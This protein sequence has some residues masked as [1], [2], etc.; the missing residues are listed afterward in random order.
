MRFAELRRRFRAKRCVIRMTGGLDRAAWGWRQR[1]RRPAAASDRK[2]NRSRPA[3]CA[4]PANRDRGVASGGDVGASPN[5]DQKRASERQQSP[6]I[7]DVNNGCSGNK[8]AQCAGKTGW[9]RRMPQYRFY[10]LEKQGRAVIAHI[11]LTLDEDSTAIACAVQLIA[12]GDVQ[13][14]QEE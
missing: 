5:P 12:G 3:G 13:V 4:A 7:G 9:G 8:S 2:Q 1:S 6:Q 14:W 11:E 10:N